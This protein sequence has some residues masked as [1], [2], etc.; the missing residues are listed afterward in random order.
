VGDQL[1]VAM[2]QRLRG[3]LRPGDTAARFGGDEFTILCEE[4]AGAED[5]VAI[6]ERVI[7]A[8]AKPFQ[9]DD[10]EAYL[11]TSVGIALA[12]GA[13]DRPEALVRDAD[14]A[15]YQA[16]QRGKARWMLFDD[17]MRAKAVARLELENAL[18]R[19]LDRGELSVLYQPIVAL[20]TGRVLGVEALVRWE[21]EA[22]G[23]PPPEEWLPLA[24]EVG[25]IVPIGEWVLAEACRAAASW[26][27]DDDFT[28]AVNVS[29]RQLAQPDFPQAVRRIVQEAGLP[30]GRLCLE[31]TESSMLL[32]REHTAAT[33]RTL[34]DTGVRV[35][36][37]DFGTGCSSI[38]HLRSFPIDTL[39]VD[40]SFVRDL[41][42]DDAA[43]PIVAAVVKLAH[44]L[45]LRA[46]AE[47]I[48]TAQQ[49][50]QV[51]DMGC[52]AGQ[53][54]CLHPPLRAE[55]VTALL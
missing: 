24:E 18:H 42:T 20:S 52:D 31:V 4:I 41:D 12:T 48:E 19:A 14:A 39:K 55:E 33:L 8:V 29:A 51:K 47:G 2:A 25:L 10:A 53:G 35:A 23:S 50:Q 13:G 5:A 9:L 37:D 38:A 22:V 17:A 21:N 26:A 44:A 27:T 49:L 54:S 28:V 40:A 16:K 32:D 46:V 1:I 6:T 3:V 11:S 30:P 15:M 43:M 36:L 34:R 7:A 45:G